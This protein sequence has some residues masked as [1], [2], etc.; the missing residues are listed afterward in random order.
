MF[1]KDTWDPL[2]I[3]GINMSP[4]LTAAPVLLQYIKTH[5]AIRKSN[6]AGGGCRRR[7]QEEVAGGGCRRR[8]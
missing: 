5:A 6:K 3:R 8:L 7:L 4:S 1:G 2:I